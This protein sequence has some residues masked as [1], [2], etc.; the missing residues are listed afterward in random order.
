MPEGWA[1]DESLFA[2]SSVFY[3]RGRI[4]YP[5]GLRDAFADAAELHGSPRLIDVGCG[6]G[7]VAL[8][9]ADLFAEVVGVDA[10]RGMIEQ[11]TWLATK[12]NLTNA[13]WFRLRAEELP[14]GLGTFRYATF[15]QSFHWMERELVAARVFGMLDP[16]GAFVHVGGQEIE[17]PPPE[18]PLP[19]PLPPADDIRRLKQSYLGPQRR[20]GQGML[21]HGTPGN[22]REVLQAAGFE[23][24]VSIR[25]RGRQALERTVDDVVAHVFSVSGSAPHLFG[26]RLGDFE[27]DLRVRLT[28]A[29][30]AG[31][32][33]EPIPD[34]ALVFYT[35]PDSGSCIAVPSALAL[36][37]GRLHLQM[38]CN[39]TLRPGV[40]GSGERRS[41][42][43]NVPST[44]YSPRHI[45][46]AA[47]RG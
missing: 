35:G 43:R 23:A 47:V 4:P 28:A 7:T 20:A 19:H 26:D 29:S 24:P 32:F 40:R 17:T 33:S 21:R 5:A 44:G 15:A 9:L 3:D 30:D 11:A 27:H 18:Q 37:L 46:M 38:R 42:A 14:A 45:G 39:E 1:W 22:E 16:G 2:G 41:C 34:L 25:V 12:R 6:P 10:D 13:R 31:F 36:A 8:R